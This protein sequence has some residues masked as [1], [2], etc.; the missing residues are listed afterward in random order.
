MHDLQCIR[1]KGLETELCKQFRQDHEGVSTY[2]VAKKKST[3]L[4]SIIQ[5]GDGRRKLNLLPPDLL[6]AAAVLLM[7]PLVMVI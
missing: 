5:A 4:G 1:P 2:R 6:S 3:L 7:L